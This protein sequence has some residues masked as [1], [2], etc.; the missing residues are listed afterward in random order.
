M[1]AASGWPH[2]VP[3]WS[4][5]VCQFRGALIV[6]GDLGGSGAYERVR[7]AKERLVKLL[8]ERLGAVETSV[9]L[10][11]IADHRH[12]A[13][14]ILER[15]KQQDRVAK[16]LGSLQGFIGPA[17]RLLEEMRYA[18]CVHHRVENA[19]DRCV[20][21][22]PSCEGDGFVDQGLPAFERTSVR[23]FLTQHGEDQRPIR[24]VSGKPCRGRLQDLDLVRVD[25]S[26]RC[27]EAAIVGE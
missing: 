11:E 23:E 3:I 15:P 6:S 7:P 13:S 5:A 17:Q 22:G 16:S 10:D 18:D 24:M 21:T 8:G 1:S 25:L 19:H 27:D 2:S 14:A 12:V 4:A 9:E 26:D 20:V